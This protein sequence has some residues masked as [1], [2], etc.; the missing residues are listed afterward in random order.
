VRRSL[1]G[2]KPQPFSSEQGGQGWKMFRTT[3]RVD[4]AGAGGASQIHLARLPYK[5]LAPLLSESGWLASHPR[6]LCLASAI[7]SDVISAAILFPA[8]ERG[9]AKKACWIFIGAGNS[10]V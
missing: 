7:C 9:G 10:N 2:F 3:L 4:T 8:I 6:A 5:S 1:P